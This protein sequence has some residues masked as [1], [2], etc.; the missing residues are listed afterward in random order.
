MENKRLVTIGITAVLGLFVVSNVSVELLQV[1]AYAVSPHGK[2]TEAIIN[3]YESTRNDTFSQAEEMAMITGSRDEDKA[4]RYLNHFHDPT[5][6]TGVLKYE[7]SASWVSSIVEQANWGLGKYGTSGLKKNAPLFSGEKDYT[8]ER[9]VYEYVYGEPERGAEALGHVLHLIQDATVP[10]HVR[11]DMHPYQWGVGDKDDYE[12]FTKKNLTAALSNAGS[13]SAKRF[14]SIQ[15]AIRRTARFTQENFMSS[16]TLFEGYSL[17]SRDSLQLEVA[18]GEGKGQYFGVGSQ[19]KVVRI[20]RD[21][22][23]DNDEVIEAYFITDKNNKILTENW[24]VLSQHAISSG[25]G[26]LDL[27]FREVE[28]EK[29]TGR[30]QAMN[31]SRNETDRFVKALAFTRDSKARLTSLAA[32]DIYELNKEEMDGYFDAAAAYGINVPA[33]ARESALKEKT[34]RRETQ[35]ANVITSIQQLPTRTVQQTSQPTQV[36]PPPVVLPPER[37]A[38]VTTIPTPTIVPE[39][40]LVPAPVISPAPTPSNPSPF[41][42]GGYAYGGGG[43][44]ADTEAPDAPVITTD[45][46]EVFATTMPHIAGTAEAGATITLAYASSTESTVATEGTWEF[47]STAYAEGTTAILLTATDDSGNVSSAT[48]AVVRVAI[49]PDVP[50]LTSPTTTNLATTTVTFMGTADDGNILTGVIGTTTATTTIVN[51]LWSLGPFVLN[52][53]DT[54][55]SFKQTDDDG[56]TSSSY[57]STFTVDTTAPSASVVQIVECAYTLRTDGGCLLADTDATVSWSAIADAAYY[58]ITVGGVE[59]AT[60]TTTTTAITLTDNAT[61]TVAVIAYDSVGNTSTSSAVTVE[62][63]TSPIVISEIAWGGTVANEDDEWLELYNRTNYELDVS[64]ITITDSDGGTSIPLSGTIAT[65][66]VYWNYRTYIIERGDG[67]ATTRPEDLAYTFDT[68]S[69]NGE[70]LVMMLATSTISVV[71]DRTPAVSTC[72]GWCAGDDSD[73]RRSMERI[74]V[75]ASGALASNWRTHDGYSYTIY[76]DSGSN[77]IFGT[78]WMENSAGFPSFGY[79]CAPYTTPFEEGGTYS[80]TVPAKMEI[81]NCTYLSGGYSKMSIPTRIKSRGYGGLYKGSVGN[82]T[83]INFHMLGGINSAQ[84]G[85]I[86]DSLENG[87]NM[88]TVLWRTHPVPSSSQYTIYYNEMN[89]YLTG[90]STTTPST[91]YEIIN[92][93]YSE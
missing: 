11:N 70:E 2:I 5:T 88:F 58:G 1:E 84:N 36:S 14:S 66:P 63:I 47:S 43:V 29:R 26:V 24:E 91:D 39:P 42:P 79:Y 28:Q 20:F 81:K 55:V 68:L 40:V 33:I 18:E 67:S 19:G 64:N 17:P 23:K 32:A 86:N 25:V 12:E 44:S 74:D 4:M 10:A 57:A 69:N 22:D 9:A 72:A 54:A 56:D 41:S 65:D 89:D 31:K 85:D 53:G 60:T 51:G 38:Q 77:Y 27:F 80:P 34:P 48:D 46:S 52:E 3:A 16:D 93:I 15:D 78:P 35:P 7:S 50:I 59:G 45:L 82:S 90:A 62:V 87:D 30:L 83:R 8:W 92:W 6:G 21:R 75:D 49:V 76:K 61:S 13:I 73:R 37:V 71:L